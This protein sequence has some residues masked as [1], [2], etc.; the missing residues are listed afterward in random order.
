MINLK[1]LD[2]KSLSIYSKNELYEGENLADCITVQVSD[3]WKKDY[4]CTLNLLTSHTQTGDVFILNEDTDYFIPDYLLTVPQELYIWVE[5]RQGDTIIKSSVVALN[6][7][8]HHRVDTIVT[9]IQISAFEQ[10]LQNAIALNQQTKA[11][12]A[13]IE[14][15]LNNANFPGLNIIQRIE[16]IENFINN[17]QFMVCVEKEEE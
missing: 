2:N 15:I 1:L 9:D 11:I 6:V 4:E 8:A 7:N 10:A 5:M 16:S 17:T 3:K 14:K 13:E 12:K